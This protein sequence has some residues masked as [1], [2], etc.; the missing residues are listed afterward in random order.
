MA[1][2]MKRPFRLFGEGEEDIHIGIDEKRLLGG[3]RFRLSIAD[4][5]GGKHAP[6]GFERLDQRQPFLVRCARAM[7]D[8]DDSTFA[9]VEIGDFD[10][11][12]GE[13]LQVIITPALGSPLY[14]EPP[15]AEKGEGN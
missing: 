7:T 4:E 5:I 13:L 1:H 11:S 12:D 14:V 15:S 2:E 10:A 3:P 8:D 9:L 6:I